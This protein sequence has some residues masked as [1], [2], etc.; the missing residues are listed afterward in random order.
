M[1]Q[2]VYKDLAELERIHAAAVQAR[3]L[4]DRPS[5]TAMFG[6]QLVSRHATE[7]VAG[8]SLAETVARAAGISAR[9]LKDLLWER[10]H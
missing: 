3:A 1:R 9:E 5:G 8:E 4:R 10:T 7:S 2:R 6:E